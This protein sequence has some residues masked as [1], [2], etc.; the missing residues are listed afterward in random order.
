M[1][2]QLEHAADQAWRRYSTA[3]LTNQDTRADRFKAWSDA[4]DQLAAQRAQHL[5]ATV[6]ARK[7]T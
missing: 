4:D 5:A 1:I 7:T 6:A 3:V 2:E